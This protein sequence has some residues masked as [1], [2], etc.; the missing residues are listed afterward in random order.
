MGIILRSGG[1][2][3]PTFWRG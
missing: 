1:T 3:Y 2:A